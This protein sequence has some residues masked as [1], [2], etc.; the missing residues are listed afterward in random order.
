MVRVMAALD[1]FDALTA[2]RPYR[3]ALPYDE[4]VRIMSHEAAQGTLDT[5]VV[6][7]LLSMGH[8]LP[9][10]I[11]QSPTIYRRTRTS[12]RRTA[13]NQGH[14]GHR[15]VGPASGRRNPQVQRLVRDA[16]RDG[17]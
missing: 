2:E 1:V 17:A 11:T 7:I 8:S 5:D 4:A 3:K 10:D 13:N 16:D 14:G 6:E 9:A 15:G 12:E